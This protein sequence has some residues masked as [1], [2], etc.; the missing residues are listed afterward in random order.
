MKEIILDLVKK[1][2][3]LPLPVDLHSLKQ[4]LN[5]LPLTDEYIPHELTEHLLI[6]KQLNDTVDNAFTHAALLIDSEKKASIWDEANQ[7]NLAIQSEID[8]LEKTIAFTKAELF[9]RYKHIESQTNTYL[10]TPQACNETEY[11]GQQKLIVTQ[12]STTLAEQYIKKSTYITNIRYVLLQNEMDEVRNQLADLDFIY[13]QETNKSNI[14][15][16]NSERNDLERYVSQLN[17]LNMRFAE[18][19]STTQVNQTITQLTTQLE[20]LDQELRIIQE[21]IN[22]HELPKEIQT[23]LTDEFNKTLKLELNE[24]PQSTDATQLLIKNYEDKIHNFLAYFIPTTWNVNLWNFTQWDTNVQKDK[25]EQKEYTDSVSFLKLLNEQINLPLEKRKIELEKQNLSQKLPHIQDNIE[26]S[27]T[28]KIINEAISLFNKAQSFIPSSGLNEDSTAVDIYSTILLNIPIFSEQLNQKTQILKLYSEAQ[29]IEQ[30]IDELLTSSQLMPVTE[31]SLPCVEEARDK[32]ESLEQEQRAR[33]EIKLLQDKCQK[34][35]KTFQNLEQLFQELESKILEQKKI[36]HFMSA[37][38]HL[39]LSQ[40]DQEQI[41]QTI[42]G[43][44]T[45]IA[46]LFEKT[47]DLNDKLSQ[48][49]LSDKEQLAAVIKLDTNNTPILNLPSETNTDETAN[50]SPPAQIIDT[51]APLLK[52]TPLDEEQSPIVSLNTEPQMN[53]TQLKSEDNI[54]VP[55]QLNIGLDSNDTPDNENDNSN[56]TDTSQNNDEQPPLEKVIS[57]QQIDEEEINAYVEQILAAK[58][59]INTVESTSL[60]FPDTNTLLDTIENNTNIVVDEDIPQQEE[61]LASIKNQ[62]P[63]NNDTIVLVEPETRADALTTQINAATPDFSAQNNLAIATDNYNPPPSSLRDLPPVES[64]VSSIQETRVEH[65]ETPDP[66]F[67]NQ[68][69]PKDQRDSCSDNNPSCTPMLLLHS[70]ITTGLLKSPSNIQTWYQ[71]LYQATQS[72]SNNELHTNQATHLLHDIL[73]ELDYKKERDVLHAYM[74]LCP[75]PLLDSTQLL[76]LK[77]TVPV[78]DTP[79]N[80]ANV[81]TDCPNILKPF[82]Q[83]YLKLKKEHPIEA[84]LF[85]DAISSI[86]QLLIHS[87]SETKSTVISQFPSLGK[88]PRYEPLKRH[89]GFLKLWEQLEDVCR[90]LIGK[91]TGQPEHEYSKRPCFFKTKSAY[92]IEKA[93]SLAQ[94]LIQD[95]NIRI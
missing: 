30:S 69:M 63:A 58:E 51:D 76:V 1:I 71:E 74:R 49:A 66:E 52:V 22:Q 77:P 28:S 39:P 43:M 48:H 17:E 11:N 50:S 61:V 24:E 68:D 36:I 3:A 42:E 47:I 87:K 91:I 16:I 79:L 5:Q 21:K 56:D 90:L 41:N 81:F 89:R 72:V 8:G 23:R 31:I 94:K 40:K 55:M 2:S 12:L 85:L 84:A 82:Y 88:D 29:L 46:L 95:P 9:S 53:Q 70:K 83:H 65:E 78:V 13:H 93:D 73:F 32:E 54:E 38:E 18:Q 34:Y 44:I 20:R 67:E 80:E 14:S 60:T 62:T 27:D 15:S 64:E 45:E 59:S 10:T 7:Q 86:H 57:E 19:L 26:F 37:K 4:Q 33:D 6:L 92:L 35:L 25:A 75:T